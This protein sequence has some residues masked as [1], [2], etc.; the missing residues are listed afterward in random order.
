[1]FTYFFH[2]C[3]SGQTKI[4]KSKSPACRFKSL[5]KTRRLHPICVIRGDH[6]KRMHRDFESSRESGEWF[7][8]SAA[9]IAAITEMS[10]NMID[11]DANGKPIFPGQI[12]KKPIAKDEIM[13]QFG[14]PPDIIEKI[15]AIANRERRSRRNQCAVILKNYIKSLSE[16]ESTKP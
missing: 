5:A 15:D 6:E 14:L 8:L 7:K 11:W 10:G 4:G 9:Q 16:T 12:Y 3:V 2:D 1:M 13:V